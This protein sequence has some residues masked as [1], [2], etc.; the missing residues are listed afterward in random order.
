MLSEMIQLAKE[1]QTMYITD[2]TTKIHNCESLTEVYCVVDMIDDDEQI[3]YTIPIPNK[4]VDIA[5][6]EEYFY[7]KVY[8]IL[9]TLGG[10]KMTFY[11]DKEDDRVRTIVESIEDV[12][13]INDSRKERQGYAKCTN[14]TE[15]MIE[16]LCHTT[17]TIEVKDVSEKADNIKSK[18]VMKYTPDYI[19]IVDGLTGI[20]CGID[21][22]GTDIKLAVSID[23]KI[24]FFKEY[25]WCPANKTYMDDLINPIIV[26]VELMRAQLTYEAKGGSDRIKSLLQIAMAKDANDKDILDCVT[27]CKS[28]YSDEMVKFDG[29]GMCFPDVVV[30]NKIVG[31]EV[32]K[33][34]GIRNNEV[35]DY[36]TEFKK[37]TDLNDLLQVHCS[38]LGTVKMTNDGPMASYTAAV[39]IA[40]ELG[41]ESVKDGI[42]AH[43]LGT[44][45]GTG[46]VNEAGEIP[47]IPLEV[48]NYVIDL[49]SDIQK[50]FEPDDLRSVNNFN[51]RI[52]G[53]LQKYASQSGVFRLAIK[54]FEQERPD[55]YQE[56]FDKGYVVE[57][58]DGLYVP[59]EPIDMRKA[60]LEHVMSLPEREACPV[61]ERIFREI[62]EYLAITW[63][64]TEEILKPKAKSR[65][66]FGRLVKNQ[67]CFELMQEGA[68]SLVKDIE[69][70]V[71]DDTMA[72]TPLMKQL[73]EH[74]EYTVAQFAQAVGAIY[75]VMSD[76]I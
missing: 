65:Y 46:W 14:V 68:K 22:G 19:N 28:H 33:T 71:A 30:K 34:R 53:T 12:L 69:F 50:G 58:K 20:M 23:Q 17:F 66:L 60:F 16:N 47:E 21:I 43:T 6:I 5:L 29:I 67:R 63:L 54:Y 18:A 1:D 70:I 31:G 57:E 76:R 11:I 61:C 10:R 48:Y 35:V 51:T 56:L 24:A 72:N 32:L 55:L 3:A 39:E 8:N 26:L 36:E 13:G 44:E 64:E 7:G 75:F 62:G 37:L 38:Q 40:Y 9:S 2:F 42:F 74:P 41:N 49:G 4:G 73:S 45:L 27:A 52:P 59:I 15:R 25:D